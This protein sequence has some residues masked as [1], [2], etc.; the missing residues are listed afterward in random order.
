MRSSFCIRYEK[1]GDVGNQ[2]QENPIWHLAYPKAI[3]W[4]DSALIHGSLPCIKKEL[5]MVAHEEKRDNARAGMAADYR[6]DF[7]VSDGL[8]REALLN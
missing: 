2:I 1:P 7:M 8:N 5:T 6:A 3:K 4:G